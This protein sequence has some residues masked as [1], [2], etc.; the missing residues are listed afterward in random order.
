MKKELKEMNEALFIIDMNEGFCEEG[1]L[2]DPS[3]KQIVPNIIPIIKTILEKGEGLFVVNDKHNKDSVELK[4]YD[5]HCHNEKESR[6]IKELRIYEEYADR[7]FYKNSTC[8]LFAPGMMEMLMEMVNLKRVIIVGCCTDICIQNFAIALRNFFDELNMDID[9]IV[10][11]NAV[12]TFHIPK[13]HERG[14]NNERAYI[15]ME[16]TGIKLVKSL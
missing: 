8:A 2:A 1:N 6:T 9:I 4:R 16:N 12:E 3:I 7:L 15:V 5:E 10:P 13:V 14:E 11:K